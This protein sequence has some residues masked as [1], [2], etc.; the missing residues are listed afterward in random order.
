MGA[1]P[2]AIKDKHPHS[3]WY[4]GVFRAL[5]KVTADQ[6]LVIA[7]WLLRGAPGGFSLPVPPGPYFPRCTDT[8]GAE[9]S[10]LLAAAKNHPS[11]DD[12]YGEAT[13]PGLALALETAARGYAKLYPNR[14]AAE[15]VH[16]PMHPAPLGNVR[17]LKPDGL[18]WKSRLILD[19]RA[20]RANT[21]ASL[22]ER[23]VLPRGI[24]HARD[25]AQLLA[26]VPADTP[27]EVVVTMILDHADAFH[28]VPLAPQEVGFCC[29]DLGAEGFLVFWGMG[30][31]G[32]AFPLTFGRVSSFVGRATQ[33]MF[34]Q[35]VARLQTYVDDPI[36][37]VRGSPQFSPEVFDVTI[38]L[39]LLMGASLSWKKGS[40]SSTGWHTWIGIAFSTDGPN[41]IMEITS[42]FK[43]TLIQGLSPLRAGRG[44]I[45]ATQARRIVGQAQRLAQVVP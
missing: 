22:L 2:E 20:N 44:H 12:S 11:F 17:R 4:A 5:Q 26:H 43:D 37:S 28:E 39:W 27:E 34:H 42:Q 21:L 35:N 8:P 33:A 7:D 19:L 3:C 29:A 18:S 14:E 38:L 36:L 15:A 32:R 10:D 16:G 13:P 40:T 9:V 30:F 25:L 41:A 1:P 24:D 31:G 23:V 6:D 45:S